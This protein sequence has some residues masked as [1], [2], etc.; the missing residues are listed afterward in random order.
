VRLKECV[1]ATSGYE[2][3]AVRLLRGKIFGGCHGWGE[4][5]VKCGGRGIITRM[6]RSW[7]GYWRF[8]GNADNHIGS[9]SCEVK[10]LVLCMTIEPRRRFSMVHDTWRSHQF[11]QPPTSIEGSTRVWVF[12]EIGMHRCRFSQF[13]S[14]PRQ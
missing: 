11:P 14:D 6:N 3:W 7:A 1:A 8:S 13:P 9:A 12:Q 2:R 10:G 4:V 5:E